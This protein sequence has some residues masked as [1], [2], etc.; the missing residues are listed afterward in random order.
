MAATKDRAVSTVVIGEEK[1]WRGMVAT[2]KAFRVPGA[3][4]E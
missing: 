4:V 2:E 3:V 1:R